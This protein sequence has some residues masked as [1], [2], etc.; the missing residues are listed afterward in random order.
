MAGRLGDPRWTHQGELPESLR[1]DWGSDYKLGPRSAPYHLTRGEIHV[2]D[3]SSLKLATPIQYLPGMGPARADRLAKL[4]L[5]TAQDVLFLFPRDYEFPAPSESIDRLKE[6]EP[7]SLVGTI[8][9]AELVSRTPGKSMFGAIVENETGAVR[10][11]FFNQPFRAE[12]LTLDR[13]VLISGV[14]KLHGLRMEFSHPKVIILDDREAVPGPRILPVYPLTDGIKQ[15]DLRRLS[16]EVS[17]SLSGELTEVMPASL[18]HRAAEALR[19]RG[20]FGCTT[21]SLNRSQRSSPISFVPATWSSSGTTTDRT[22]FTA[23]LPRL[24]PG[25]ACGHNN[26]AS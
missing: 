9:D 15:S 7:A 11:L 10:I 23:R 16:R 24:L 3:H 25:Q 1:Y 18:R 13:R 20:S 2:K 8:S 6:G 21:T 17:E 26:C 22:E 4:G 14:P 19:A 12:Q 5:R